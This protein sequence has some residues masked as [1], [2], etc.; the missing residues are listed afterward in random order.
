LARLNPLRLDL[1][2][3]NQ[4]RLWAV[5]GILIISFSAIFVRFAEVTPTTSAFFRATYALPFLFAL[6]LW[7]RHS[8]RRPPRDR[9][10]A[11]AAGIFLGLDL[12]F[13]HRAI[14]MI[15]AGL[16][17]VL[18]NT[19][20]VFV[21]F[22]AWVLYGERPS[23]RALVAAPIVFV[24]V[25]LISGLGNA[26]AFGSDP[27]RGAIF[28]ILTGITYAIFLLGFRAA[29]SSLAA[30]VGPLL[31]ATLGATLGA[32]A[33]GAVDGQLD[34]AITWPAHAWLLALAV[35]SQV[36]GWQLIGAALPRLPALETSVFMLLQPMLTTIWAR[37]LFAEHLATS[38]IVGMLLVLAGVG[39][40]SS[41][42]PG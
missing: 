15:G 39:W 9:L 33:V 2:N 28:G 18:G 10:V 29:G 1:A 16:A 7:Q 31:D 23:R 42:R 26:N 4:A 21:G 34:F 24:G 25:V 35:G 19:Q 38:Q 17:T 27:R 20:V 12:A 8:S 5:A 22:L 36:I 11:V 13:W 32:L 6:W 3:L 30:P 40:F 41:S 14:E 37:L